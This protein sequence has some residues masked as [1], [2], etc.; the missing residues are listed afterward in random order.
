[1]AERDK[2]DHIITCQLE[3]F[4]TRNG[5]AVYLTDEHKNRRECLF[6]RESYSNVTPTVQYSYYRR[7]CISHV[8]PNPKGSLLMKGAYFYA[9]YYCSDGFRSKQT[10]ISHLITH[11]QDRS[12]CSECAEPFETEKDKF[13][14]INMSHKSMPC[15][16]CGKLFAY[17]GNTAEA[18]EMLNKH[19]DNCCFEKV[20][21][22]ENCG[23]CGKR[24]RSLFYAK[25][26]ASASVELGW[27][28][29][30]HVIN[31]RHTRTHQELKKTSAQQCLTCRRI[32]ASNKS[33]RT[34]A[35]LHVLPRDKL[36]FES[37]KIQC[38]LKCADCDKMCR[39]SFKTRAQLAEHIAETHFLV[40]SCDYDP[41]RSKC[42]FDCK[43]KK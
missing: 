42:K 43:L 35:L 34:H 11:Y 32:V 23:L 25:S 33:M 18:R 29:V 40:Q 22:L 21:A 17:N 6:C 19:Y 31:C 36:F 27:T 8:L 2:V 7:H 24:P 12:N 1:M 16:S 28:S 37:A 3:D 30:S 10:L 26:N 41:S 15:P 20:K 14:H 5:R 39:H 13:I 38:Q 9:C 4:P